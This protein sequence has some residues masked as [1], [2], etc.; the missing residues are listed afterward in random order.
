MGR[1]GFLGIFQGPTKIGQRT[2]AES[3]A[4]L[5][6]EVGLLF[7]HVVT[8]VLDQDGDLRVE[9]FGSGVEVDQ[10]RQ[11]PL[12]DVVLLKTFEGYVLDAWHSGPSN[13]IEHL[14]F[15]R[16]MDRQLLDD[17]IDDLT[18]LDMR[19]V[20]CLF[21]SFEQLLNCFVVCAEE[22][23][24]IHGGRSTQKFAAQTPA[25]VSAWEQ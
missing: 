24:C 14:L 11:H 10:F 15:D 12:D 4:N 13:W 25:T 3:V 21:E 7:L 18:L 22:S 6:E 2:P 5:R 1:S 16:G 9:A 23:D 17:P 19:V 20:A 8:H